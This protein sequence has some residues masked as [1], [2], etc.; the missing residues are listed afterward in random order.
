MSVAIAEAVRLSARPR[1]LKKRIPINHSIALQFGTHGSIHS[2]RRSLRF[3][4]GFG[5][6]QGPVVETS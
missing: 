2:L 1:D 3:R 5:F 4:F 6:V